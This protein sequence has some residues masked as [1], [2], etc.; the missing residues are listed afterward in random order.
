MCQR[1]GGFNNHPAPF[2]QSPRLSGDYSLVSSAL[3]P[4][5][6][7]RLRNLVRQ[8]RALVA[9]ACPNDNLISEQGVV[10]D[11][12]CVDEMLPGSLLL[13]PAKQA[14]RCFKGS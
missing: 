11:P 13:A 5:G 4:V 2:W 6:H 10:A 8:L 12:L 1:R 3:V 14:N 7:E 9:Q